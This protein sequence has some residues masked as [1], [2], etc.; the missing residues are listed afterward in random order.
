[1]HK[2]RLAKEIAWHEGQFRSDHPLN[3]WPFHSVDRHS[4]SMDTAKTALFGSVASR[5][6]S[7][8]PNTVLL[9]PAG[10]FGDLRYVKH[11]WPRAA[12]HAVDIADAG[13]KEHPEI[14][15]VV[16][17]ISEHLP[18]P[19]WHFDAVISTLFFHHVIDEGFDT[20]LRELRRVLRPGGLFVTLEFS[21]LHP[22]FWITRPLKRVFGNI[23][24]Q[25]DHERPVFP[26]R[27][28][29]AMRRLGFENIQTFGCSFGHNRMPV[30]VTK[31]LNAAFAPLLQVPILQYSAWQIGFVALR[32]SI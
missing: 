13:L 29:Q 28:V 22:L 17:D 20:Y 3:R 32:G 15:S 30:P 31:V 23:T 14:P 27:L 19:D 6:P 26:W 7:F 2:E 10:H 9:A 1:M 5:F 18:Y 4:A 12:V 11:L 21:W 16:A 8:H 25:V 24:G